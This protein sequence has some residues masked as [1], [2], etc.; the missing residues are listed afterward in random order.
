MTLEGVAFCLHREFYDCFFKCFSANQIGVISILHENIIIIIKTISGMKPGKV[1]DQ[2]LVT[3]RKALGNINKENQGL[4]VFGLKQNSANPLKPLKLADNTN[5]VTPRRALGSINKDP[6]AASIKTP[7][8]KPFCDPA[9][10]KPENIK[11]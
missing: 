1:L 3:P 2:N 8:F 6:R 11:V 7:S 4:K 5:L 9:S 10:G